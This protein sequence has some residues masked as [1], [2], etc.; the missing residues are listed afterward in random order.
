[1]KTIN[2]QDKRRTN[3]IICDGAIAI[4]SIL[5]AILI[6][7]S[8]KNV[9]GKVILAAGII[10]ALL[11]VL[12]IAS[13]LAVSKKHFEY[14]SDTAL[15]PNELILLDENN[16]PL[17]S[18][19][20]NGKTSA[21]IGRENKDDEVDIDLKDCEYSAFIEPQHAALNYAQG[22]WYIEDISSTNGVW[23]KKAEDG[24][25]YRLNDRPCRISAGDIIYIANTRLLFT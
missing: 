19:A 8:L 1:M 13:K 21:I 11:S 7:I 15:V 9:L 22:N 6:Y 3:K 23:I 2:R 5:A 16:R 4:T 24:M 20:L 12:D 18:Y 10:F 14:K 17:R 25:K